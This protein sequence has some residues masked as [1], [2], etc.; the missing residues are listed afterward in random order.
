MLWVMIN[1]LISAA[2]RLTVNLLE[3]KQRGAVRR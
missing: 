2:V 3:T 1:L